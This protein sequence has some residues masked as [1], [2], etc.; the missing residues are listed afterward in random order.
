MPDYRAIYDTI[1]EQQAN[2]NSSQNSPGFL[3][4]VLEQ[5]WLQTL[6]GRSLDFGC[7]AGFVV[8][9]L[10]Q[11]PFQLEV[12]AVDVSEVAVS[13]TLTRLRQLRPGAGDERVQRLT[14]LTLPFADD[15]FGLV[16]CFDVLEHLDET[17]ILAAW[18]ELQR[19]LRRGGMFFGSVSCRPSGSIDQFGDNLHRTVRSID[20][21][22]QLL[23]PDRLEYHRD[24][25]QLTLWK[26]IKKQLHRSS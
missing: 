11:S 19:V 9:F 23:D 26:K 7:G 14:D 10:S 6:G 18:S 22:Q 3:N 13:K 1:I 16:T 8:E 17:D 25:G 4:C 5:R 21:W 24:S 15:F 2:Y 12:W 20:W